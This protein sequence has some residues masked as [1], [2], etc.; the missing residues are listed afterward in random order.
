MNRIGSLYAS[1]AGDHRYGETLVVLYDAATDTANV[2][3]IGVAPVGGM[4]GPGGT[5]PPDVRFTETLFKPTGATLVK[6]IKKVTG[7][8]NFNFKEYGKSTK[9]FSWVGVG[10]GLSTTTCN[11][12]LVRARSV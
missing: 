9:R 1:I 4:D 12:A 2:K 6:L 8:R 10:H 3:V 5:Y 11:E 7:N